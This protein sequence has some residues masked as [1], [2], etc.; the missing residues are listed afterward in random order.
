MAH[1]FSG[2]EGMDEVRRIDSN[3]AKLPGMAGLTIVENSLRA[4][5]VAA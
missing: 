5:G 2:D 1:L 3:L 4:R